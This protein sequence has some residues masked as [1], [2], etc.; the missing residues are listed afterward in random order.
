MTLFA[1]T[2]MLALA[3]GGSLALMATASQAHERHY[4]HPIHH[5]G[6]GRYMSTSAAAPVLAPA[7]RSFPAAQYE[8]DNANSKNPS[9]PGYAQNMGGETGGPGRNLIPE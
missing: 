4:L 8:N 6:G 3:A 5:T 7:V 1:R 9:L 2:T